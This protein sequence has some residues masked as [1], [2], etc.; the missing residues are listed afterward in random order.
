LHVDDT[1]WRIVGDDM[2]SGQNITVVGV[3]GVL[4]KVEKTA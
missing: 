3:D 4:L 1:T 2:P